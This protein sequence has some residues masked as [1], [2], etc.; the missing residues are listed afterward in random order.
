MTLIPHMMAYGTNLNDSSYF[1]SFRSLRTV[2]FS[3]DKYTF[4]DNY[5]YPVSF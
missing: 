4:H 5:Y 3:Y 1:P 2:K